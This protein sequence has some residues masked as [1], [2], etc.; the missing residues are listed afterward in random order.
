M[1]KKRPAKGRYFVPASLF[2]LITAWLVRIWANS[3]SLWYDELYTLLFHVA[4]PWP[5]I[6]SR[7]PYS[8]NNHLLSTL[9]IKAVVSINGGLRSGSNL[10][11]PV[12]LSTASTLPFRLISLVAGSLFPLALMWKLRERWGLAMLLGFIAALHPWLIAA[13]TEARGYMLLLLLSLLATN[14]LAIFE[15]KF[16]WGY[17]AAMTLALYTVPIAG[18]VLLAHALAMAWLHRTGFKRWLQAAGLILT[19]TL[20]LYWPF[21]GG[22]TSSVAAHKTGLGATEF[23]AYLATLGQHL[24]SGWSYGPW[25]AAAPAAAIL[26]GLPLAWRHVPSLRDGIVTFGVAFLLAI[27]CA[28]FIA[29]MQWPRLALWGAPLFVMAGCGWV[30]ASANLGHGRAVRIVLTATAGSLL[31]APLLWSDWQLTR[32]PPQAILDGIAY[33]T[34]ASG[35]REITTVIVYAGSEESILY[36]DYVRGQMM[37]AYMLPQLEAIEKSGDEIWVVVLYP[38]ALDGDEPAFA[39]HLREKYAVQQVLPGR[40][41]PVVV[42][43]P[44]KAHH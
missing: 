11:I 5:A 7:G 32:T 3:G 39:A 27:L 37:V 4:R 41:S 25:W 15:K 44:R 29:N 9:L 1:A 8:P 6:I 20:L 2:V 38:A 14:C 13:S 33:P 17:V 23:A 16:S 26:A 28:A 30:T 21:L 34:N 12:V 31:L 36:W 19:A 40:V 35:D 42:Y 24:I 22:I 43:G 10:P 18:Q